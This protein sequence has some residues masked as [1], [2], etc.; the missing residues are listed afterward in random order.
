MPEA[1]SRAVRDLN[2]SR[3]VGLDL[4]RIYLGVGLFVRGALFIT[5]PE[6]LLALINAHGDWFWPAAIA[7][8]VAAVHI[9]GGIMLAFG[10][11]TRLAAVVQLPVLAGAVFV[12]HWGEGLLGEGQSL[13]FAGLV[14][15]ML[16]VFAVF[17][18]GPLS[19]DARLRKMDTT[20]DD[21]TPVEGPYAP[22]GAR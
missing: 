4:L 11:Y 1:L 18:A 5:R 9:A 2:K 3:E 13:E 21:R 20:V 17:G 6:A 19:V 16:V 12:T 15:F 22:R 14:L 8:Y 10:L 7:H